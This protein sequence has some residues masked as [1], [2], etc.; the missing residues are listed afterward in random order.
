MRAILNGVRPQAVATWIEDGDPQ[1]FRRP[2]TWWLLSTLFL[3]ADG[4]GLFATQGIHPGAGTGKGGGGLDQSADSIQVLMNAVW[5]LCAGLM[6]GHMGPTLQLMRKQKTVL[7]FAV[8]ALF[9][10]FWSQAPGLTFHKSIILFLYLLFS[11]FFVTYYRPGDQMR[12]L[13]ALGAIMGLGSVFWII[14]LPKYGVHGTG[15]WKGIFGQK[16]FLGEAMFYLFS[17]LPFTPIHSWRRLRTISLQA[18]LPFGLILLSNSRTSL[19]MSFIVVAVRVLGALLTRARREAIPLLF[20]IAGLGVAIVPVTVAV[21]LPLLGRDLSLTGRTNY[22]SLLLPLAL[23][24]PWLGHG[25]QAFFIGPGGEPGPVVFGTGTG[26]ILSADNGYLDI[27]LQC[28]VAGLALIFA[29]LIV[30]AHDFL[31]LL[32]RPPVPLEALWY[33]GL[34]IATFV[35]AV[36]ENL[37]W[38]PTRISPLILAVASAGLASLRYQT[39]SSSRG[40]T[41]LKVEI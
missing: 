22:W 3:M 31:T 16:N 34:L 24:R 32:R 6:F 27:G 18:L 19:F 36:T 12:L 11:W 37:L 40:R 30:S 21:I 35:G 4:G 7:A 13:L 14:F 23:K 29:M 1:L 33:G 9:S 8:L 26:A 28:G 2:R 25:Y 17:A 39:A 20:Y 15:E 10:T 41:T 5:V 38:K